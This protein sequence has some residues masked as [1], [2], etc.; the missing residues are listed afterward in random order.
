MKKRRG[1]RYNSLVNLYL[2]HMLQKSTIIVF[3]ISIIF[4]LGCAYLVSNPWLE[5]IDY[6]ASYNDF[7]QLYLSQLMLIIQIF[8][9]IICATLVINLTLQSSSFDILFVSYLSRKRV[10]I[11]KLT[12]LTLILV[13][14]SILETIIIYSIGYICYIKFSF[15]YNIVRTLSNI[16]SSML[17]NSLFSMAITTIIPIIFIPMILLLINIVLIILCNNYDRISDG[18][19]SIIPILK[20]DSVN[21]ILILDNPLISLIL[22]LLLGFLYI[23]IYEVKDLKN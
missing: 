1:Y 3:T 14:L 23:S 21:N 17:W 7:H 10:C 6:I 2:G 11:A 22:I 18:M 5:E 9:G 16:L 19:S 8:N 12:A 20:L 15:D 13:I 4:I